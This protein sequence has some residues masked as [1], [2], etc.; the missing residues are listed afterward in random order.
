[1]NSEEERAREADAE[2]LGCCGALA[3]GAL[4]GLGLAL[5]LAVLGPPAGFAP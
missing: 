2:A 4:L 5:L 3:V 1:M